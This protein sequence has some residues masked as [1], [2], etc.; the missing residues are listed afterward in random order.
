MNKTEL[1]SLVAKNAGITKAA[2][3]AAVS[4]TL[5]A[6]KNTL[7]EGE[8]VMIPGFGSFD[9]RIRAARIASNPRTHEKI[10]VPESKFI[11]FTA[12]KALRDSL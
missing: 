11:K 12:S 5:D 4:A 7:A 2:A 10:E 8:K 1:V 3:D 6:I 9:V